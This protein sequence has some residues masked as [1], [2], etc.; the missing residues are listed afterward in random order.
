MPLSDGDIEGLPLTGRLLCR[1]QGS[2]PAVQCAHIVWIQL[3][4]ITV[5]HLDLIISTQVDAAVAS[6][7]NIDLDGQVEIIVELE[8][9]ITIR[10]YVDVESD[11]LCPVLVP[12]ANVF[13][14]WLDVLAG[15][16]MGGVEEVDD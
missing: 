1:L 13:Y 8:V 15:R 14:P 12:F 9:H 10:I 5:Y 6:L 7:R 2:Y 4:A 3:L 16:A 11:P